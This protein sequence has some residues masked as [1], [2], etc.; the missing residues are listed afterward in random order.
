MKRRHTHHTHQQSPA[1]NLLIFVST[2]INAMIFFF[3]YS[4]YWG[5]HCYS[6]ANK[7]KSWDKNVTRNQH[8]ELMVLNRPIIIAVGFLGGAHQGTMHSSCWK[9]D[10]MRNENSSFESTCLVSWILYPAE[11]SAVTNNL[12]MFSW[13]CPDFKSESSF[14]VATEWDAASDIPMLFSIDNVS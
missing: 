11:A 13:P 10:M 12:A 4:L 2:Y 3:F 1:R 14:I 9:L 5:D 8:E 7:L 6:F